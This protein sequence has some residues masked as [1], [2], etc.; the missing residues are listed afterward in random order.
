MTLTAPSHITGH[1]G[2]GD[3]KAAS[4]ARSDRLQWVADHVNQGHSALAISEA[5]GLTQQ[6]A[7]LLICFARRKRMINVDAVSQARTD[8]VT[9]IAR[10]DFDR[11]ESH[12]RVS[13]PCFPGEAGELGPDP[14]HETTPRFTLVRPPAQPDRISAV[15]AVIRVEAGRAQ[16]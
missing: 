4:A 12:N 11:S 3:R 13:L 9:Y 7:T 1:I 16:A 8:R 14:R 10:T 15:I 6:A 2:K 5:L